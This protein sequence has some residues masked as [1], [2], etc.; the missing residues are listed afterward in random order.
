MHSRG[1]WKVINENGVPTWIAG[2]AH[3]HGTDRYSEIAV[4][5]RR[6]AAHRDADDNARLIAAAPDLLAAC[7]AALQALIPHAQSD[8][9]LAVVEQIHAAITRATGIAP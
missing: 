3:Q 4:I 5:Q 7:Y 8:R 9:E 6:G 1:P 2:H